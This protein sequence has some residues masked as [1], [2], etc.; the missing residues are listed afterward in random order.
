MLLKKITYH[1]LASACIIVVL[2]SGCRQH[3]TPPVLSVNK[4]YLV[5]DGI[6][7]PGNDSTIIQLSRT[8]KLSDTVKPAPSPETGARVQVIG[9]NNDAHEL[10]ADANG[11]YVS[12]GLNLNV[13]EKYRLD[14]TTANGQQFRS[15]FVEVKQ[16]PAIDSL[17][18]DND[19]TGNVQ[20]YAN[21]NNLE[22][23]SA[24]YKWDY[25][26]TWQYHSAFNS[27]FDW[28]DHH[29][30]FRAN[31]QHAYNC[32]VTKPS[33]NIVIGSTAKLKD[34]IVS[35]QPIVK[36]ENGTQKIWIMYSV[37]VRQYVLTKEAYAFWNAVKQTTEQLGSLFDVQPTQLQSNIHCISDT[38]QVV[39]GYV[40]IS[41][42][43]TKRLFI[44]HRD[45]SYWQ[46]IPYYEAL[47]CGLK[48]IGLDEIEGY[49][50]V[51]GVHFYTYIGTATGG[52][53]YILMPAI[54]AD[55][56]EHGDGTNVKPAFWP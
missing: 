44:A 11:R 49:F 46:Y 31:N 52:G 2:V 35:R 45:V 47:D 54:C 30:V 17:N 8:I 50:P 25:V 5:V 9:E 56:R 13:N 27:Y 16:T 12:P 15:D 6:I 48:G 28:V 42:I 14:I 4:G 40:S 36:L 22:N 21:A 7:V 55:C 39:I 34:N 26:E 10:V 37:Y 23:T 20:V 29:E 3:Y 32:W 53:G 41:S 18:W 51:N 1:H 43:Q 19:S 33:T 38:G 24:Y